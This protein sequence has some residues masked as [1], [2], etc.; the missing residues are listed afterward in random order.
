MNRWRITHIAPT[1]Q[2][3]RLLVHAATNA[4][5]TAQVERALGAALALACIRLTADTT[6]HQ[7]TDRLCLPC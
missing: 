6:H 7:H 1:G 2:R 4:A 3:R 5:A